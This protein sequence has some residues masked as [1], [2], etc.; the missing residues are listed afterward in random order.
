MTE[1]PA[2]VRNFWCSCRVTLNVVF[3]MWLNIVRFTS[4]INVLITEGFR[5][6]RRK[7]ET[8][9][10]WR[11]SASS[12]PLQIKCKMFPFEYHLCTNKDLL[13]IATLKVTNVFG[14]SE[15]TKLCSK[16]LILV[17]LN[18]KYYKHWDVLYCKINL[19]APTKSNAESSDYH[20]QDW[21]ESR[22]VIYYGEL[23]CQ[24]V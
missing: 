23:K 17:I 4:Q 5:K 6:N 14:K 11:Y 13:N 16:F 12:L 10:I 2:L 1:I 3:T 19:T 7:I 18:F 20:Q 8:T 9:Q 21:L 22:K 15:S 24:V